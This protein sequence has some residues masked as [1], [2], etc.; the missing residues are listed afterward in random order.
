MRTEHFMH[1]GVTARLT[2]RQSASPGHP[3]VLESVEIT[4]AGGTGA[5]VVDLAGGKV[6]LSANLLRQVMTVAHLLQ[7]P[8]EEPEIETITPSKHGKQKY[9]YKPF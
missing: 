4:C 7:F 5:E 8:P 3:D 9:P 2:Y 1:E 6:R